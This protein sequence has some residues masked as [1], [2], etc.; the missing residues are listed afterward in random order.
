MTLK[1]VSAAMRQELTSL[2][3]HAI[4]KICHGHF[5]L[6]KALF[7]SRPVPLKFWVRVRD[8]QSRWGIRENDILMLPYELRRAH[9]LDAVPLEIEHL[10]GTE[11]RGACSLDQGT[12]AILWQD[13]CTSG[14]TSILEYGAGA[15][16]LVLGAFADKAFRELDKDLRI[17]SIEQDAEYGEGVRQRLEEAGLAHRVQ[18]IHI[19]LDDMANYDADK[20]RGELAGHAKLDWV[21]IDGPAGPSGCRLKTLPTLMEFCQPGASWFL[22]DA[23]RDAEL[24]I[25]EQWDSLDGVR[26]EGICAVGKGLARGSVK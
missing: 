13:L 10:L 22:D 16:T 25:L 19:P 20:L 9:H 24:S 3:R 7:R 2:K 18:I 4:A 5:L 12:I 15:T 6:L 23:F 14:P 17:L 1:A 21:L 11:D 26:V 8:V